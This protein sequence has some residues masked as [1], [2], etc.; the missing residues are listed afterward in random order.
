MTA[1]HEVRVR[2]AVAELADALLAAMR[3]AEAGPG[4]DRLL[5]V[6]EAA[7]M[8]GIGRSALYAELA[9]GRLR[10]LKIGRRRVVP[11]GAIAEYVRRDP[12]T[13]TNEKA[14]RAIVTPRVAVPAAIVADRSH[15]TRSHR[16]AV[17]SD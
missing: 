3:A 9:A 12:M 5:S 1:E 17:R 16:R 2:E 14:T 4:P 6:N 13:P 11:S 15:R 10:S 8:L 7:E